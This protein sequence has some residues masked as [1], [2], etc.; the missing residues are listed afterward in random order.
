[1]NILIAYWSGTGNTEAMANAVAQGV[2]KAGKHADVVHVADQPDVSAYD[3][4][5]FGCPA[6]G[7]EVLEESEFEPF[8][9]QAEGTLMNKKVALFGSLQTVKLLV[10]RVKSRSRKTRDLSLTKT[11][12]LRKRANRLQQATRSVYSLSLLLLFFLQSS[13]SLGICPTT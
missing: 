5:I 1:M 7:A 12:K 4:I 10:T 8:F 6:M 13:G 11:R 9:M 2:E 3:Y